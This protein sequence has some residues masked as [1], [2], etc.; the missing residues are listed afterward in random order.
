MSG[1]LVLGALHY[2]VVVDAPRLPAIDETLP[3]KAVDYRFGGKG[4]NQAVAAACMGAR[5]SMAGRVGRDAA[6]GVL[7]RA[8]ETA[9]VDAKLVKETDAPTGMSVAITLPSGD[10][11]AVIVSGANLDN[12][13]RIDWKDPPDTVL[14]Q[15]EI[16]EAANLELIHRL[17][18]KTRLITN[19]APARNLP[20]DIVRRTDVLIVNRVEA[21]T[22]TGE[23]HP[24]KMARALAKRTGG[25]VVVT[26]GE[27]G[28][29]HVCDDE[30]RLFP[31]PKVAVVSTHGAGDMFT[32]A[33]AARLSDGEFMM[34]AIDFAIGAAAFFVSVPISERRSIT[35]DA[36]EAFLTR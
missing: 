11:G 26:M 24:T 3:G 28:L 15:N 20:D 23:A 1:I 29:V 27:R 7:R 2:D 12:D 30:T 33:L 22:L 14:I 10:Y 18:A 16:P 34:D 5:V 25:A 21:E 8:L 13:G 19:A 17:P 6:A 9:G 36:V 32:G 31:I 35:R 4:G